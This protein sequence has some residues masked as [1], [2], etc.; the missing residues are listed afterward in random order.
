M[1]QGI[2]EQSASPEEIYEQ[3]ATSFVA[4]FMG[5]DNRMIGII[6]AFDTSSGEATVDINGITLRTSRFLSA[7]GA[8]QGKELIGKRASV[9]FRPE[10]TCFAETTRE[11]TFEGEI[12]FFNYQ[13]NTTQ[14]VFHAAGFPLRSLVHGKAVAAGGKALFSVDRS[15]VLVEVEDRG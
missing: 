6:S 7:R 4:R 5:F 12:D 14:Y 10:D 3:P 8:H 11:N 2:I 13:G 9:F 15:K 1:N